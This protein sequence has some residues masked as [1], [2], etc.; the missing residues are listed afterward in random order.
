MNPVGWFEIPASEINESKSFYDFIFDIEI[1]IND[2]GGLIMGWFPFD[3]EK[4]GCSGALVQNEGY[5]PSYEGTMVYFS[6]ED[7]ETTLEKVKEKGGKVITE[8][9]S[10][11]EYGFVGHFED[12]AGNRVGLHSMK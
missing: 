10:I 7:I 1:Q 11:G 6:V 9:M 2:F 4:P 12:I 8:K 3:H 5:T